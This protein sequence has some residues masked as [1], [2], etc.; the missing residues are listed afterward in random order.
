MRAEFKYFQAPLTYLFVIVEKC[1][2]RPTT[3]M[4]CC[5]AD[6]HSGLR[7]VTSQ[8]QSLSA[9]AIS[10][11]CVRIGSKLARQHATK[12]LVAAQTH[13]SRLRNVM[14]ESQSLLPAANSPRYVR[15]TSKLARQSLRVHFAQRKVRA[16]Q[17]GMP[18][19][20]RTPQGDG[21][22]HRKHTADGRKAQARVKR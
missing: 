11:R 20:G 5:G 19:N 9:A 17:G 3:G 8:P 12:R 18:A 10:T 22:C 21:K 6:S 2:A 15:I 7:N 14:S 16:P 13:I 4:S 1:C